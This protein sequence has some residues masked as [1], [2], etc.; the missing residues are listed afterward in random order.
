[1]K[2]SVVLPTFNEQANIVPLIAAIKANISLP[3]EVEI[4]VVDDNSP[5]GTYAR[6][7]EA[8]GADPAV[9]LFLRTEDHGLAKSIW[10]GIQNA[11][12]EF[13]LVMDTDFTH[14]PDEIPLMLHIVEKT[15]LVSGSRFC[16]G[17][18]MDSTVHY[19][20]SFS[21]NLLIRL[22]IRTQVQDNLGGFWVA[23][24]DLIRK[25][26][27]DDIFYGYGDYYFRMLHYL[28]RMKARFVEVPAHYTQR[29]SGTS[30]SNFLK[31]LF[32]YSTQAIKLARKRSYIDHLYGESAKNAPQS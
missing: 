29:A 27:R 10:T 21:Y 15:D 16:P 32:K 20:A 3:W 13:V 6:V 22:I 12:T 30:K 11:N 17:G 5:D 31:L 9:K 2:V 7:K 18:S 19:L 1:M 14:R 28:Q 24:T 25:L 8:Y 23:R 4:I 26:P